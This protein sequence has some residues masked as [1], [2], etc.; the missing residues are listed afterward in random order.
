MTDRFGE[1]RP[2]GEFH[3]MSAPELAARRR[4]SLMTALALF[5]FVIL[6]F[7]ITVSRLGDTAGQLSQAKD[8]SGA[9]E[10]AHRDAPA[11]E[12]APAEPDQ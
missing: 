8:F 5:A 1:G 10:K 9:L 6:I 7:V 12:S 3:T 2:T 11:P 4:R